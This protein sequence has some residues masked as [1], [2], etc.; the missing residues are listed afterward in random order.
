MKP[1]PLNHRC[2]TAALLALWLAASGA[3]A[4]VSVT[5]LARLTGTNGPAPGAY[6]VAPLVQGSDGNLYGTTIRNGSIE[7]SGC[8]KLNPSG[9]F[10][11][12]LGV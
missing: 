1:T 4:E 10:Y 5:T 12:Q 6:S 7:S 11:A 9:C 2:A 3:R 8:S